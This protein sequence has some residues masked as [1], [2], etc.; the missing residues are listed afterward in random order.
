MHKLLFLGAVVA[1]SACGPVI[2]ATGGDSRGFALSGFDAVRLAGSDDV[3]VVRGAAFSVVA[4]GPADDIAKLDIRTEGTTLVVSRERSWNIG[5]TWGKPTVVTVTMP[6]IRAATVT[7]SGDIT[8]DRVDGPVFEG[9]VTGSGNLGLA[10]V[11][12]SSI[13][14]NITGSGNIDAVGRAG[15][16]SIALTGS[17]TVDADKLIAGTAAV[18][19]R[20]SGNVRAA[21]RDSAAIMMSGS[22]DATVSGTRNCKITKAGSGDARCTG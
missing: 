12:A 17:G 6:T 7:G 1:L 19:V 10:A 18:A 21:A 14:L 20:G 13:K 2:G 11:D 4:N 8:V 3:R 16:A 15:A 9:T 5:M 22:G